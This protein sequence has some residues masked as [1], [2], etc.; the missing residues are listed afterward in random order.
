MKKLFLVSL[1]LLAVFILT[2]CPK[3]KPPTKAS[4]ALI[5]YKGKVNQDITVN[6]FS[7]IDNVNLT[8]A[9]TKKVQGSNANIRIEARDVGSAGTSSFRGW[10]KTD[11]AGV[12]EIT[13]KGVKAPLET[14]IHKKTITV[15]E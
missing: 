5:V 15:S 2:G 6:T 3:P 7:L 13:A 9:I 4:F 10:F 14:V 12:Y 1:S 8:V 11:K